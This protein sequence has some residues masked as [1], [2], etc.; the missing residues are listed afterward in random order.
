MPRVLG[1]ELQPG[2]FYPIIT[3]TLEYQGR[4]QQT[5]AIVDSGADQ[6]MIP[7]EVIAGLG[8]DVSRLPK[9]PPNIG[10]GG[11]DQRLCDLEVSWRGY[12]FANRVVVAEAGSLPIALAGRGELFQKFTVRFAWH[13][14]PPYMD[15]DPIAGYEPTAGKPTKTH[16]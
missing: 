12:V 16:V 3:L 6:T 15:L 14:V 11:A 10:A 9:A 1:Y 5:L 13:K 7:A 4:F 2:R 8:I